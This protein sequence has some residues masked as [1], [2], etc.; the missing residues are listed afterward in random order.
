M[1]VYEQITAIVADKL[2]LSTDA[3]TPDTDLEAIGA[4]SLDIVEILIAV[5][6]RFGIYVPDSQVIEMRTTA[7]LSAYVEENV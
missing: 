1:T 2:H 3:I 6:D 5:E 4:D 7:E